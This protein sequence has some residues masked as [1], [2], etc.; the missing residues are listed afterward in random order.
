MKTRMLMLVSMAL[1]I[2][3][4]TG[5]AAAQQ[6]TTCTASG[7]LN[8]APPL[9][10]VYC[11]QNGTPLWLVTDYSSTQLKVEYVPT[12]QYQ[13]ITLAQNSFTQVCL[14]GV[15]CANINQGTISNNQLPVSLTGF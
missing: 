8:L 5:S 13:Y 9:N 11:Y 3:L 14:S 6:N 2:G 10:A 15:G 1:F 4:M 12:G 7:D